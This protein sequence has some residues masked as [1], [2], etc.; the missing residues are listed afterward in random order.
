M[1]Y[2][3]AYDTNIIAEVVETFEATPVMD[4]PLTVYKVWFEENPSLYWFEAIE[5]DKL[6]EYYLETK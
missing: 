2:R 3:H 5:P 1:K 6:R 4:K